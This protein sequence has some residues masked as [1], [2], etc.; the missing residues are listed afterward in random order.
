MN[1]NTFAQ[2]ITAEEGGA[3]S[4]PIGQV[5]E[6]MRLVLERLAS[7]PDDDAM[8]IVRRYRRVDRIDRGGKR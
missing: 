6:V 5:K 2:A 3:V 4:L 1:L 8:K 7:M